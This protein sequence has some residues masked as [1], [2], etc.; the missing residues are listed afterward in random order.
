MRKIRPSKATK[1]LRRFRRW[2]WLLSILLVLGG[3]IIINAWGFSSV[4]YYVDWYAV[5]TKELNIFGILGVIMLFAGVFCF[6]MWIRT[7]F[8]MKTAAPCPVCGTLL[9]QRETVCPHCKTGLNWGNSGD[10]WHPKE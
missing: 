7:I 3:F 8:T 9:M 6:I 10:A 1:K 5:Y 4:K 2:G